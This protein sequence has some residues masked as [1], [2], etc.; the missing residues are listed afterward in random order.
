MKTA[1]YYGAPLCRCCGNRAQKKVGPLAWKCQKTGITW[2]YRLTAR[3]GLVPMSKMGAE[4]L[5]DERR[6]I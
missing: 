6:P 2:H 4:A 5:D 3:E 1:T